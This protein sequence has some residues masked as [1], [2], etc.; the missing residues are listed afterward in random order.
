LLDSLLQEV[1]DNCV[2][3][4]G[5]LFL[6]YLTLASIQ[7]ID[8]NIIFRDRKMRPLNIAHRGYSGLFPEHS[9]IGYQQAILAGADFIECDLQF[10]K[11]KVG[12]CHHNYYLSETTD[13]S[14][15]SEF[16]NGTGLKLNLEEEGQGQDW[17][18]WQLTLK[19][20][21]KLRL[22][23]PRAGR[24]KEHDRMYPLV[25][26]D[27]FIQIGLS[28][29]VK[30]YIELKHPA[31]Y[32]KLFTSGNSSDGVQTVEE[33]LVEALEENELQV[34]DVLLQSFDPASLLK[35]YRLSEYRLVYL[36]WQEEK[37]DQVECFSHMFYGIGIWKNLCFTSYNSTHI[38]DDSEVV[39]K[40][41][42]YGYK[43][44][45]FTIRN[46]DL[47]QQYQQDPYAELER[48]YN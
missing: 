48:L 5:L 33:I 35:L 14:H 39:E 30:L 38:G 44:H 13:I 29:N 34:E 20:I 23:Q 9:A 43:V 45:V 11:D 4:S 3:M 46:D 37:F 25:T 42:S 7:Q 15:K 22:K 47:H 40:L 18:I 17:I 27:E 2:N 12:I 19:Q 6:S 28:G 24:P 8:A 31:I 32:N 26:L 10:T 36:I 41:Q 16:D 21:E 1:E